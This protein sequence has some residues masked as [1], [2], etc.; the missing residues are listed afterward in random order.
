MFTKLPKKDCH[1]YLHLMHPELGPA[2]VLH[3][4]ETV[5]HMK[6]QSEVGELG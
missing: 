6:E 4:N 5:Q 1:T 2:F 3:S